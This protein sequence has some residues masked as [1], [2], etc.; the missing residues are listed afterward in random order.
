[1]RRAAVTTRALAAR[2]MCSAAERPRL[3]ELRQKLQEE[4]N[5]AVKGTERGSLLKQK[6]PKPEWLKA[7]GANAMAMHSVCGFASN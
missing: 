6:L 5:Y 2:S 3:Q 1:M 4:Q 7:V